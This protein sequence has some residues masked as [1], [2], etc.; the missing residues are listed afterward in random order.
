MVGCPV[1]KVLI[2]LIQDVLNKNQIKIGD[3]EVEYLLTEQIWTVFF[4]KEK[5]GKDYQLFIS[6]LISLTVKY[7]GAFGRG[8]MNTKLLGEYHPST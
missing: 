5:Q 2:I 4:N 8:E 6:K 7:N 1:Q 3:L